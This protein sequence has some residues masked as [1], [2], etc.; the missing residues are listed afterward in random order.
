MTWHQNSRQ[1]DN[2]GKLSC[3]WDCKVGRFSPKGV[4]T[5]AE[6]GQSSGRSCDAL[7]GACNS[8]TLGFASD[9]QE[10]LE[11][12]GEFVFGVESVREINTSDSAV[13]VNLNSKKGRY[14]NARLVWMLIQILTSKFQCSWFHK[15]CEWNRTSWTEFDSS[16]HQV[17]WAWCRWKAWHGWYSSS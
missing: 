12:W 1:S 5:T 4:P 3:C 9:G 7:L 17:S 14:E 11:F 8:L 2:Q 15:L 6:G 16:L 10:E 13:G